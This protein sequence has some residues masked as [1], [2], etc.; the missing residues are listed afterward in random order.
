MTASDNPS[1]WKRGRDFN[2]LTRAGQIGRAIA[3]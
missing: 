2:N 3:A 1:K